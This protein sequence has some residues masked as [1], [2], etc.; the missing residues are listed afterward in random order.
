MSITDYL[1]I[2]VALSM[3]AFSV[4]ICK[5]LSMKKLIVSQAIIVGLYFGIAQGLMPVIGYFLGVS[6]EDAIKSFDHWI[7][8][9]LLLIIGGKMLVDVIRGEDECECEGC[10]GNG[11]ADVSVKIMLPMAIATSID[12]LAV[13]VSYAFLGANIWIAALL[14]ALVT[15]IFCFAGV[16]VGCFFGSRWRKPAQIVGGLMLI[17]IGVK[18]LFEHLLDKA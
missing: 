1:L 8:F 4:S 17:G 18:I 16:G 10:S 15:F 5:G 11:K 7:A 12:A 14:I 2:G 13:G 9:V 6:F 3:D